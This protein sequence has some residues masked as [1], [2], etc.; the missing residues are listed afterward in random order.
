MKPLISII[1]P[2]YNVEKYIEKCI[3][4]LLEQSYKNIEIILINDGSSD[5]SHVICDNLKEKD[6]RITVI[7]K[8]NEGVS[9]ARNTGID[10]MHGDFVT[11]VDGDDYV[12]TDFI[13]VMYNAIEK[14][15]AD[16]STCG[17]YRVDFDGTLK[18]VYHLSDNPDEIIVLSGEESIKNMFYG[19]TCSASSGSKLYKKHIFSSLRYPNYV[20]GED[21]FIV[22]HAFKQ[23]AMVAH[24]NKPLYFYVQQQMSVTNAKCN[25]IKFYDYVKL[26]DHI[27]SIDKNC[28]NKEYFSA[29]ANRLIEN[30][31][32]AYM[33]LRN[34]P[35]MFAN[36]KK[37]IEENI[38]KY[39]KFVITNPNAEQRVKIACLLSYG[40]MS[41]LNSVYDMFIK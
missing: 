11:F 22:Y 16:I 9:K 12:S 24:T 26:Y 38:K 6:N 23:S 18:Q 25:Y 2:V 20:M 19:K 37:H 31:F 4:S 27:M 33:K 1:V 28:K 32:W 10:A 30:N 5:N 15:G 36:E 21:T 35:N 13:E 40:G 14:T 29:I 34:C 8:T 3:D 41:A 7:H 39:R 17:H